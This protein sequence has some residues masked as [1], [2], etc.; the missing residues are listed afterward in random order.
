MKFDKVFCIHHYASLLGFCNKSLF[1]QNALTIQFFFHNLSKRY[2]RKVYTSLSFVIPVIVFTLAYNIPKFFELTTTTKTVSG[3]VLGTKFEECIT[4]VFNNDTNLNSYVSRD[5]TSINELSNHSSTNDFTFNISTSKED[6]F[7][8]AQ[9]STKMILESCCNCTKK[10]FLDSSDNADC[11]AYKITSFI[12]NLVE[13]LSDPE[14]RHNL[15]TFQTVLNV[16]WNM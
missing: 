3:D 8:V 7:F 14:G 2:F 6:I 1:Y 12:L 4:R 16:R 15:Q 5:K 13:Y 10:K 9:Q 11:N